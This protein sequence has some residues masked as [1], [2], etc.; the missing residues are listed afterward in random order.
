MPEWLRVSLRKSDL[1]RVIPNMKRCRLAMFLSPVFLLVLASAIA[2]GT[3]AATDTPATAQEA[4]PS[5]KL[6]VVATTNI[7]ADWAQQV[8]GDRVE[9]FSLVPVDS[10]PHTFQPGAQDVSRIANADLVLSIGL[11]LEAGWV[12]EILESVATNPSSIVELGE[13]VDPIAFTEDH[14]EELGLLEGISHVVHEVEEGEISA[15]EGL[16]EVAE[17]LAAADALEVMEGEEELPAKV[18]EILARA[19][20]GGLAAEDAIEAIE[21]L[22]VKGEEEHERHG[23]GEFDPHFWLDPLRVKEA[24]NGIA[25]QLSTLDPE[26]QI[27]YQDNAAAYNRQLD[28]LH[29]WIQE[30][31]AELLEERRLLVTSHDSFQYFA[32]RYGFIVVGTVLPVTTEQEPTAQEMAGLI[33]DIRE[34]GAPAVFGES[35]HSDRLAQRI[36]EETGAVL[37][38]SLYTGS[39]GAEGGEAGTYLDMM[40]HNV[41]T[42]VEG[43]R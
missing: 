24:V 40:R 33:D 21:A 14:S 39:L 30:R 16:K 4:P 5:P 27:L 3:P 22:V 18:M 29:A 11:S 15:A 8:G 7:V 1:R 37:I 38:G 25:A 20:A 42:I 43:L 35:T 12:A 10:D 19:E 2:C 41:K 34:H 17:L 31:V 13:G 26:G 32:R 6:D 23:H 36:A 28:T 9:V